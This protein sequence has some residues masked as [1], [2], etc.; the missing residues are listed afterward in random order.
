MSCYALLLHRSTGQRDFA[1]GTPVSGRTD[2]A[3]QHLVG[4]LL[5]TVCVRV[6]IEPDGRVRELVR[7]TAAALAGA[8]EHQSVPFGDVV[9]AVR[10]E[11]ANTRNPLFSAFCSVLDTA[12]PALTM[13]QVRTE[14]VAADHTVARFDLNATFALELETPIVQMEFSQALFGPGTARRIGD[15][16]V[17]V[18]DWVAAD[19]DQLCSAVPLIGHA[20]RSEVLA[21][22]NG[23]GRA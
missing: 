5:N 6:R 23:G 20:E 13:A 19:P 22:L 16:L 11:R 10:A 17:R 8:L 21:L 2:G 9:R 1:I 7:R 18:L 15:R 3:S 14:P 12:P 4:C